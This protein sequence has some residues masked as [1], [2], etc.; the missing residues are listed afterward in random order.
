M[1]TIALD[2]AVAVYPLGLI[3]ITYFLVKLHDRFI[4]FVVFCKPCTWCFAR[5]RREWNIRSSLIS[6]FATFL[7]L[8]YVKILNVSCVLLIPSLVYN[9]NG[10][11]MPKM[12]LYY[13][14][15]MEYFG[16]E[17]LPY[18]ILAIIV[19][20]VF[21]FAPLILLLLYPCRCFQSFLNHCHLQSQTLRIFMDSFQG[22]YRHKPR[23]CR[24][25][26]AFY[27]A[28]RIAIL[29]M[30]S[31]TRTGFA[32]FLVAITTIPFAILLYVVRPYRCSVYN[33]INGT[34]VILL[35]IGCFSAVTTD[36]SGSYSSLVRLVRNLA[37]ILL[38]SYAGCLLMYKCIPRRLTTK[39]KC[40]VHKWRTQ[41]GLPDET[42]SLLHRV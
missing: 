24:Y 17:H 8:S 12:Y 15:A 22:C 25:F 37:V 19:F 28:L 4:C 14:G 35:S 31:I 20:A 41:D 5:I 1:Q 9:V 23:D 40:W 21:N 30:G 34:L 32:I 26:A 11:L 3:V 39:L 29:L 13:D 10:T 27:L 36:F 2:Y 38:Q 16:S 42:E 7:V 33:N 6:A 18:A